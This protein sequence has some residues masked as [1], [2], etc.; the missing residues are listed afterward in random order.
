MSEL[1]IEFGKIADAFSAYVKGVREKAD[2]A[3]HDEED[4]PLGCLYAYKEIEAEA[5]H[6]ECVAWD[7]FGGWI[8]RCESGEFSNGYQQIPELLVIQSLFRTL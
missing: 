7:Y 2:S 1:N 6:Y 8:S 4:R 5:S 3:L